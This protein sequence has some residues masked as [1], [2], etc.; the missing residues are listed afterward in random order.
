[1]AWV[2]NTEKQWTQSQC[3]MR[4]ISPDH[5]VG[6][7]IRGYKLLANIPWDRVDEVIIP[8]NINDKFHWFLVVFRI[9]SRCLYVYDSMMGGSVH[10]TK[11]KEVVDKLATMIPLFLT[12]TGFYGKR[13]DLYAN[14]LPDYQQKSH[15]EPLSIKNVTHVPQQEESSNDC[16]LYTSLF[17]EYMSNGVFDILHIDIDSTYHRQRYATL[18]WHY[19]KS[20]NDE[21]ATSESEVT[22]TVASKKGGPRTHKEQVIDTTNYP[23]PKF[24]IRK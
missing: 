21:G 14:N 9:K 13:L 3:D 12:S 20:K 16:G 8:V 6:Q 18:L 5:D 4:C 1:M 2:D 10:S 22:G 19:E 24:R 7:C 23:T 15:S 11:V 17:A